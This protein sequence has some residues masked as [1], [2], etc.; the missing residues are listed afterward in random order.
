M[1]SGACPP[2]RHKL[3]LFDGASGLTNPV[4]DTSI[5][6]GRLALAAPAI[7]QHLV[8]LADNP[9]GKRPILQRFFRLPH[10]STV[11]EHLTDVVPALGRL[12]FLSGFELQ[13]LA[14]GGL[15]TLYP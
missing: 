9:L 4:G 11:V 3:G 8:R 2:Y 14:H 6:T 13:H 1:A 7:Q 15:S 10:G 5:L 12:R